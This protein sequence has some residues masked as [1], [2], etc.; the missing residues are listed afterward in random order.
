MRALTMDELEFVSG[1]FHPDDGGR[2]QDEHLPGDQTEFDRRFG[3][4]MGYL[5]EKYLE[6]DASVGGMEVYVVE[7]LNETGW[8]A[9]QRARVQEEMSDLSRRTREYIAQGIEA[10]AA[11]ERA[12]RELRQQ[13]WNRWFGVE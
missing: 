13:R 4:T 6:F 7:Y 10:A 8:T 5:F 1:G 11:R 9:A 2:R 12:A 3:W